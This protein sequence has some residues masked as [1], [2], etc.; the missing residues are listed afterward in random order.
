MSGVGYIILVA[1]EW[2]SKWKVII[3]KCT[4]DG[5]WIISTLPSCRPEWD[6]GW[7]WKYKSGRATAA[8]GSELVRK[9]SSSNRIEKYY[10]APMH[11][12]GTIHSTGIRSKEK[13]NSGRPSYEV[14]ESFHKS[15]P[16]IGWEKYHRSRIL[17]LPT[18][19]SI[20]MD[21]YMDMMVGWADEMQ[22]LQ[23]P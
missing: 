12:L 22:S 21:V 2:S 5:T 20:R 18:I 14:S 1:N 23:R 4:R 15:H 7:R 13:W 16:Q 19:I 8:W 9:I 3:D 10:R 6:I 17:G 11:R